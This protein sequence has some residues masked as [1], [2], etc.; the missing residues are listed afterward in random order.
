MDSEGGG[1]GDEVSTDHASINIFLD[2]NLQYY[3]WSE[4]I[5]VEIDS[6]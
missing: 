3:T 2:T 1:R 4:D 5:V 6:C